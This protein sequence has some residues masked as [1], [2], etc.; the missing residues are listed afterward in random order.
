MSFRRLFAA[1]LTMLVV[2]GCAQETVTPGGDRPQ[3]EAP[4]L[5][6]LGAPTESDLRDDL[7]LLGQYVTPNDQAFLS[8]FDALVAALGAGT[9]FGDE[10]DDLISK[11]ELEVE[12]YL[13]SPINGSLDDC[14]DGT[15][16][17]DCLTVG[18]L[19]DQ[20]I[21]DLYRF[22]GLDP[23]GTICV[24]P[25]G[26]PSSFCETQTAGDNAGF[27]YFPPAIFNQLTHISIKALQNSSVFSG[28]DEYGYV[29]EI[30]TAPISTFAGEKP[31]VVAC[32]PTD[33]PS[34]VLDRLLLAHRR[35][36]AKYG[37]NPPF[38]LLPDQEL[39]G[40]PTLE[41]FAATFCGTPE[42]T[43]SSGPSVFGL[44]V[45]S[46]LNRLLIG[47]RDFLLPSQ[48]SASNAV[49][50]ATRGFSGASGS[51]EEF[52]TF[53]AVDRGVTGAGG[54][55]EEFAPQA[56][57]EM[58]PT[59][60]AVGTASPVPVVPG[61]P[62]VTVST[63][64]NPVPLPVARVK[65]FFE[66][67][68]PG[69]AVAGM[70]SDASFDG[71]AQAVNGVIEVPTDEKGEA[72]LPCLN[73][74]TLAGYK[75]LLVS[76]DPQSVDGELCMVASAMGGCAPDYSEKYLIQTVAGPAATIEIV[77]GDGQTA[78]AYTAVAIAPKVVVKDQYSNVAP[79]VEVDWSANVG[80]IDPNGGEGSEDTG[81]TTTGGDGTS[82]LTSWTLGVGANTLLAEITTS[83]GIQ[84]V[85]FNATGTFELVL[86]NACETGGAKDDI[87]KYGF[88]FPNERGK[89]IQAI[90]LNLSSNG[91]PG[92]SE[93]YEVTLTA[94]RQA[95]ETRTA[96]AR[97]Q[98]GS[99]SSKGEE[100][101]V[102]FDFGT[103]PFPPLGGNAGST[104][105]TVQMSV[106][107]VI[108]GVELLL[109]SNRAVNMNAGGCAAG[110]KNCKPVKVPEAL[111]CNI[112]ESQLVP[113]VQ[114]Y[115]RGLAARVYTSP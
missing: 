93:N 89:I 5:T 25:P 105:V 34:D 95:G 111:G 32:V 86:A 15:N 29:L 97:L 22:V 66:L 62:T 98:S 8:K 6:P 64:G 83:D 99:N 28:L 21:A 91:A 1:A 24:V 100:N 43:S 20:I 69:G 81:T 102:I 84:S 30:R 42:A 2:T 38:G 48:L 92:L 4:G 59:A 3:P 104:P 70:E 76:F 72:V 49:L 44:S 12:K 33:T 79:G 10:L 26:A 7:S 31:I 90:G 68:A 78:D 67:V 88:Y 16:D 77:E 60:N 75:K 96:T 54:S 27:V 106:V 108:D 46:P 110:S 37:P 35:A 87:T 9:G 51:P 74:G 18:E 14:V 19:R 107:Q 115:R 47:A 52:S 13:G 53:R 94:T 112:T 113:F 73:Y 101:L 63:V 50:L 103:N 58:L 85:T 61:A 40:D 109:P 56:A 65:V 45:D 11:I 55:P 71:C 39:G 114:D 23:T 17:E 82:T 57:E 36:E 41:S 80:T